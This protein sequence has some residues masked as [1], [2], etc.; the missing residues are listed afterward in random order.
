[1][2]HKTENQKLK[3]KVQNDNAKFKNA[4]TLDYSRTLPFFFLIF[5]LSF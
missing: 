1:M 5:Y 2:S 4:D 3:C